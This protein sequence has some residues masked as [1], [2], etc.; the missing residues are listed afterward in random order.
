MT[1]SNEIWVLYF[2]YLLLLYEKTLFR[3]NKQPIYDA[4]L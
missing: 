3:A 4:I 1:Y 2:I